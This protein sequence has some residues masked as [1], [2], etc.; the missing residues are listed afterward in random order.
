MKLVKVSFAQCRLEF[1]KEQLAS[2]KRK[3]DWAVQH[4]PDCYAIAEKADIYNFYE[5]AVKMA[6]NAVTDRKEIDFD[7]EAEV[8]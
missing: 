7:Y 4:N 2:A 3:R 6:E 8:E 1:F 5:W